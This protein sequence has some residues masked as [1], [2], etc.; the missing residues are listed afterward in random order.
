MF[1]CSDPYI[2]ALNQCGCG[3]PDGQDKGLLEW[4]SSVRDSK[5]VGFADVAPEYWRDCLVLPVLFSQALEQATLENGLDVAV[6]V[7]PHPNLKAPA[8]T[9]ISTCTAEEVPHTGCLQRGS[10]DVA[11]FAAALGYIW[12]RFAAV[13]PL[14]ATAFVEA[15]HG[16]SPT[17]MSKLVPAYAWDHTQVLWAGPRATK[18]NFNS[19][20]LTDISP[21]FFEK[22]RDKFSMHLDRMEFGKLDITKPPSEQ[23]LKTHAYDLIVASSENASIVGVPV[24]RTFA[25]AFTSATAL[26]SV[27]ANLVAHGIVGDAPADS[28]VL[29]FD[30]P[31]FCLGAIIRA[32]EEHKIFILP[33]RYVAELKFNPKLRFQ[34]PTE[35]DNHGWLPGF[36]TMRANPKL[37][38]IINTYVTRQL[39]SFTAPMSEA[40]AEGLSAVF[41]DSTG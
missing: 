40:A 33:P 19:Y 28:S 16:A 2:T 8:S 10:D 24:K 17:D 27:A 39:S 36:D 32:A 22:A 13:K 5:L 35:I 30:P 29:L 15:V 34:E 7:G 18:I 38:K 4:D 25:M 9:T 21:A 37:P 31:I 3:V 26:L 20:T 14:D 23:G 6:E 12:E 1:P 11:I 41:T